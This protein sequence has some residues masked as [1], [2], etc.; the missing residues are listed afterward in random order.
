MNLTLV[1]CMCKYQ[2]LLR[3]D[4]RGRGRLGRGGCRGRLRSG[5]RRHCRGGS[6]WWLRLLRGAGVRCQG[7][8]L[9]SRNRIWGI[10]P[11]ASWVPASVVWCGCM[12]GCFSCVRPV[13]EWRMTVRGYQYSRISSTRRDGS[14]EL[15]SRL[16]KFSYYN[17]RS[18]ERHYNSAVSVGPDTPFCSGGEKCARWGTRTPTPYGTRS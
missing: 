15:T 7:F 2:L 1:N 13:E 16:V 17:G 10:W 11:Q 18:A 4:S 9:F 5:R 14:G 12:C 6:R 3:G 8:L